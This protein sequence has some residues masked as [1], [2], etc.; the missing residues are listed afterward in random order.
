[1][2]EAEQASDV[3]LDLTEVNLVDVDVVQ[4]L[5]SVCQSQRC[6]VVGRF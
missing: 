5:V 3:V 1:L 2:V 6:S 4:F